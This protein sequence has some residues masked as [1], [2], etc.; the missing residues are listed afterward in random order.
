M[1]RLITAAGLAAGLAAA[2]LG[3]TAQSSSDSV[4][5]LLGGMTRTYAVLF[6]RSFVDFTYESIARDAASGDFTVTGLRLYPRMPD[7][8][9]EG[10]TIS[11]GR[12]VISDAVEGDRI[13]SLI[14]TTDLSISPLCLMPAPRAA[15]QDLGYDGIRSDAAVITARYDLPGGGL[16]L[17]VQAGLTDA[18]SL[19]LEADFDYFWFTGLFDAVSGDE[20]PAPRPSILLRSFEASVENRGAWGRVKPMVESAVGNA[21]ALPRIVESALT[22]QLAGPSGTPGPAAQE[23]TSSLVAGLETFLAEESQLTVRA[24][25]EGG[26]WLGAAQFA[27]PEAL[28]D[29][30]QPKV[31]NRPAEVHEVLAPELLSAALTGDPE[32]SDEDRL[33]AGRALMSGIGAPRDRSA[34]VAILKPMAD[35][36]ERQAALAL[37]R[38]LS[39][40][41][42]T[43]SAYSYALRALAAGAPGAMGLADR[44][45][46]RLSAPQIRGAQASVLAGWAPDPGL[47]KRRAT[48]LEA[49][50][51]TMMRRLAIDA[52]LGRG[53]PRSYE[54]AYLWTTLAAAAG[55]RSAANL[56]TSLDARA[57]NDG[58]GAWSAAFE[59]AA[60]QA[61]NL[62]TEGGIAAALHEKSR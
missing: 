43:E 11:L 15:L 38:G 40:T 47:E 6:A 27:T 34:A 17:S 52:K 16:E 26:V 54:T 36:G 49:A 56:R 53:I 59:A 10:C 61:L 42:E 45:E 44:I 12:A 14:E 1:P 7:P 4:L 37:A 19:N 50:D 48:V 23:F 41:G 24:A 9:Q 25:P 57:A 32:L 29:A 55:D 31:S 8:A 35:A 21:A 2:P 13:A 33:A 5:D 46:A 51:P 22:D 39:E 18:L 58:E 3:A 28:I 60:S 62:W 30:L 20:M